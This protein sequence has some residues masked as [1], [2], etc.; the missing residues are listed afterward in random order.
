MPVFRF[1]SKFDIGDFVTFHTG[2]LSVPVIITEV[3]YSLR[4]REVTYTVEHTNEAIEKQY[5]GY[6]DVKECYLS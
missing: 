3:K 1:M 4:I 5:G 2:E 6:V